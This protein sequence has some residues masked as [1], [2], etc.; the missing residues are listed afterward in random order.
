M[1]KSA[2]IFV[3]IITSENGCFNTSYLYFTVQNSSFI[4][5]FLLC[6]GIKYIFV[7]LKTIQN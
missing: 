4:I 7:F 6:V 3:F 5:R 1:F 2:C